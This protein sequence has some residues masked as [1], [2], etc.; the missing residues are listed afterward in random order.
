MH[1]ASRW[2][3][4]TYLFILPSHSLY[5]D[6]NPLPPP[7]RIDFRSQPTSTLALVLETITQ[8]SGITIQPVG[9]P[10]TTPCPVTFDQTPVWQAVAQVARVTGTRLVSKDHG[11][12]LQ[13]Q[14][15]KPPL[16]AAQIAGPFRISLEEIRARI[17]LLRG[18]RLTEA[19]LQV[20]WEPGLKV[21]RLDAYPTLT[22]GLDD[23]GRK[24]SAPTIAATTTPIGNQAQSI[25]RLQG[26]DRTAQQLRRLAGKLQAVVADKMQLFSFAD[27]GRPF[28]LSQEKNGVRVTVQAVSKEGDRWRVELELVYPP[29][30]PTFESFE[31]FLGDNRLVLLPPKGGERFSTDDFEISQQLDRYRI[32]YR[33]PEKLFQD[34]PPQVLK[35]WSLLYKTPVR[36]NEVTIPFAFQNVPLP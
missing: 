30:R 26:L 35:G 6:P 12:Q 25:L 21:Y 28:P 13:L 29:D 2:I 20:Q 33:F 16:V 10:A 22:A 27:L 34:N 19:S 4:L 15:G 3:L 36:L 24:L 17:N 9:I 8:Q 7:S 18:Q 14:P 1:H 23:Q 32:R 11:R 31:S 5:A